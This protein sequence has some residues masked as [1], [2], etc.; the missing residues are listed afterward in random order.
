VAETELRDAVPGDLPVVRRILA[1]AFAGE[2]FTIGMYGPSRIQRLRGTLAGHADWPDD[3]RLVIVAT[4]DEMIVGV[5]GAT[6]AGCCSRC[7]TPGKPLPDDPS[8]DD[9]IDH[10]LRTRIGA[11]HRSY[12][13]TPHGHINS[14]AVDPGAQG[15]GIGRTLVTGLV[16]RLCAEDSLPILLECASNRARFYERCGFV[17]LDEF[18]DPA[19][20]GLGVTLMRL[21]R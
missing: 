8:P 15:A 19:G 3:D 20:P 1:L 2:P 6:R 16:D 7:D 4:L 13:Q 5:A 12:Q 17:R 18:D 14:V 21:D 10:A 11:S 9:R